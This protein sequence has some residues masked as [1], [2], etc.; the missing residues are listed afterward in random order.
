MVGRGDRLELW[1]KARW[2][3]ETNAIL[4]MDPTALEEELSQTDLRI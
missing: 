4:D 3:A 2:D 1:G